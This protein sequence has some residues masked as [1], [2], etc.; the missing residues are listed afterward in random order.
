MNNFAVCGNNLLNTEIPNGKNVQLGSI[1][2][3]VSGVDRAW[4]AAAIEGEGNLIIAQTYQRHYNHG[5]KDPR[6]SLYNGN[7]DFIKKVSSIWYDL[8]TRFY[9]QL[10]KP[11]KENHQTGIVIATNGIKSCLK[12]IDCVYPYLASKRDQFDV[13]KEYLVW[14]TTDGYSL[15]FD[16]VKAEEFAS[17]L[18]WLKH[19][20]TNPSQT[21]R[22]AS[23][24]LGWDGD[25]VDAS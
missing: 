12:I 22:R 24:P 11:R 10:R 19:N 6:I 7:I 20:Y 18:S 5:Y 2:R 23:L 15:G 14:R 25:I 3:E 1:R 17:R 8:N 9:Y 21:T 13:F 16:K 4:L